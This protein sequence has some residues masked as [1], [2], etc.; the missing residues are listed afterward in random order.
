MGIQKGA[1]CNYWL[2]NRYMD[3]YGWGGQREAGRMGKKM[4][5]V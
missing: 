1:G 2:K 4:T 3:M 5:S